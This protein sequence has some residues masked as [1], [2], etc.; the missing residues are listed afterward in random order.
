MSGGVALAFENTRFEVRSS[1]FWKS[2][3]SQV[4]FERFPQ[5]GMIEGKSRGS[6]AIYREPV[7]SCRSRKAGDSTSCQLPP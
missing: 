7:L 6:R 3:A 5:A 4:D 1:W 2:L